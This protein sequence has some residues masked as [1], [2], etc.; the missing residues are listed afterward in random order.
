MPRDAAKAIEWYQKAAA[1]GDT[2]AQYTLGLMYSNG[3]GV[4]RN[5]AK[6]MEWF[7]KSA[8]RGHVKAQAI[9][10]ADQPKLAGCKR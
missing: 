1:Q 3:D 5:D 7:Q 9:L 10:C 4:P 2:D 8:A 6:G